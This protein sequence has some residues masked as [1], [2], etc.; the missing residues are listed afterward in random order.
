M[1]L[2]ENMALV[3][4]DEVSPHLGGIEKRRRYF[5]HFVVRLLYRTEQREKLAA[6]SL[7]HKLLL[8]VLIC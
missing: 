3:R 2:V 4:F 5:L 6:L 7:T 8:Y 1:P